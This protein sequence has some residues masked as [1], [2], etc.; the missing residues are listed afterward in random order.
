MIFFLVLQMNV[1]YFD[2]TSPV[3]LLTALLYYYFFS[4]YSPLVFFLGFLLLFCFYETEF[5]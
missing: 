3:I 2:R 4:T 5:S 1:N